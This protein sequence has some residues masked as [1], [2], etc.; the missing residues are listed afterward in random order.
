[1]NRDDEI[2]QLVRSAFGS[3]ARPAH[4]TSFT[5]CPECKEHDDVLL[6]PDVENLTREAVGSSLWDP[7]CFTSPEGFACYFPALARLTLAPPDNEHDWYGIQLV[8][9]LQH[10][11][12]G[13]KLRKYC[14]LDQCSAVVAFLCHVIKTRAELLDSYC[15]TNDALLAL[16]AWTSTSETDNART[17]DA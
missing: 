9:H 17:S 15:Y 5:H 10:E 7:I 13:N 11:G 8:F 14:S 3:C 12:R 16:D 4:F 2:L 6:A 1:V